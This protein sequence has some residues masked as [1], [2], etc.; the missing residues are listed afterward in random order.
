MATPTRSPHSTPEWTSVS[1]TEGDTNRYDGCQMPGTGL[2]LALVV[3]RAQCV[4]PQAA[5]AMTQTQFVRRILKPAVFLACLGPFFYLVYRAYL[6][7]LGANP[8]ETI[9]NE[10]GIWTLRLLAATIAITPIR[11]L[12]KWNPIITFRRMIGLFAFFYG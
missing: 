3:L 7:D 2:G 8:L 1:S 11:G 9:T 12:T 4:V 10:T 6:G 5:A